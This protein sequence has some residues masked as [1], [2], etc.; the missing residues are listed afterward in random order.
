ME[1]KRPV[2]LKNKKGNTVLIE[3]LFPIDYNIKNTQK[4]ILICN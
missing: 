4:K 2:I 3:L 1:E